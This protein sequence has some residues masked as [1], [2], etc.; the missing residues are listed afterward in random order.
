[1]ERDGVKSYGSGEVGARVSSSRMIPTAYRG[2]GGS[3]IPRSFCLIHSKRWYE[4][5]GM[6]DLNRR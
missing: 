2:S 1:M 5:E 4:S 3:A 6:A